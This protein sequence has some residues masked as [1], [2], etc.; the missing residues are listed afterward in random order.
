MDL[1]DLAL[2][3]IKYQFKTFTIDA[4]GKT[5][6]VPHSQILAVKI[7]KNFE[8][9]NY[10]FIYVAVNLPGWFYSEVIKNSTNLHITLDLHYLSYRKEFDESILKAS[11]KSDL[12]G[13][14]L[15][16]VAIDTPILSEDQQIKFEKN[17]E[18]YNK[19]YAFNEYYFTEFALQNEAYLNARSVIV[20]SVLSSVDMTS[21]V[22][23]MLTKSGVSNVLMS[24]LSN[25]KTYSEFI[26]P[27]INA[28]DQLKNWIINYKLHN[29]GTILFFDLERA[30]IIS[31]DLNCTAWRNSEYKTVHVMT[32]NQYS[33]GLSM[34]SGYFASSKD[35]YHFLEIPPNSIQTANVDH[36][37][38]IDTNGEPSK[39]ITFYTNDCTMEALTP[40]KS[41][42][43]NLQLQSATKIN[44]K[45]R[46]MRYSVEM[47]PGGDFLNA[48]FNI[49][50]CK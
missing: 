14:F 24:P 6:D 31:K 8:Y 7:E 39:S 20:N 47:E 48:K 23:Y 17:E 34:G 46:L 26:I 35:K 50:L 49:T 2:S 29:A 40:N 33:Q 10:P 16:D 44:G 30:Y 27:P 3:S 21:A 11:S 37:P 4:G 42:I 1:N 15:A 28:V 5:F 25:R 43:V 36:V 22:A 12:K 41:Y 38:V 18:S 9:E 45:Y 19:T 13:R 32:L